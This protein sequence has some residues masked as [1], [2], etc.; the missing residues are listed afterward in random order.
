MI[1][2]YSTVGQVNI[3]MSEYIDEILDAFDKSDPTGCGTKSSSA[4]VLIFKGDKAF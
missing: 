2:D 3:P 1:L 4:P